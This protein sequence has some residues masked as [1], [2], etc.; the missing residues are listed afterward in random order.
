M[1]NCKICG[2]PVRS[3]NVFHTGCWETVTRP[4]G[5]DLFVM[6]SVDSRGRSRT[7]TAC[8]SCTATAAR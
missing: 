6:S 7:Q 2:K 3:A 1:A 5:G 4:H 8:R